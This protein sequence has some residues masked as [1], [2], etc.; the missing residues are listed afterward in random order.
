M[1]TNYERFIAANQALMNC[2]AAV[3]ADSYNAMPK[4]D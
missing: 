4:G 1:S 2:Y 3:S